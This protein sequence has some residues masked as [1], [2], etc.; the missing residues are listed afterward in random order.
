MHLY[1]YIDSPPYLG[2]YHI[3]FV[4][5]DARSVESM[6]ILNAAFMTLGFNV[7][8]DMTPAAIYQHKSIS[9]I[10]ISIITRV[11]VV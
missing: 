11:N 4:S 6:S 5:T 7:S 2:H 10:S 9:I 8:V 1:L 3:V